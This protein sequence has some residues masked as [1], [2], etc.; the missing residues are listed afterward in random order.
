MHEPRPVAKRPPIHRKNVVGGDDSIN[1]SLDLLCFRWILLPRDLYTRLKLPNRDCGNMQ[2]VIGPAFEP[3]DNRP[4]RSAPP[5]LGHNIRVE[6]KHQCRSGKRRRRTPPML[7]ARRDVKVTARLIRQQQLFQ[8]RT[9]GILKLPPVVN[10]HKDG[11]FGPAFSDDLRSI[12]QACLQKLAE[13]SLGILHRP[14]FHRI[15]L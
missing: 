14:A 8:C 15:H 12:P 4:M 3:G 13:P 7:A 2:I 9:R 11:N 6:E 10:W 1:P 5:K